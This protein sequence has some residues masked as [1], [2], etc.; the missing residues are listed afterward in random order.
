MKKI[1][2]LIIGCVFA[3]IAEGAF[4]LVENGESGAVICVPAKPS[5]FEE[6]T[7]RELQNY[8]K[9]ISGAELEIVKN[10][11]LPE[12]PAII[13]G[14]HPANREL[15]AALDKAATQ[16]DRFAIE[17]KGSYLHIAAPHSSGISYGGWEFLQQLGVEWLMP[18]KMGT[19]IPTQKTIKL[20]DFRQIH[21]PRCEFRS[22]TNYIDAGLEWRLEQQGAELYVR[23]M[24][25]GFNAAHMYAWRMRLNSTTQDRRDAYAILGAGH[26]YAAY[27]PIE[28]YR[29]DHPE[30]YGLRDGKRQQPG[31]AWQI[32]F[33]NQEAA[34]EFAKNALQ[35]V[36]ATLGSGVPQERIMLCV[37]PNDHEV[38]CLCDKCNAMKDPDGYSSN[39]LN[40]ANMVAAHIH[41]KYP[42]VKITYYVYHTYGRVPTKVKPAP[43]VY[44]FITAWTAFNSLAVNNAKPLMNPG[45]NRIFADVFKWFVENSAGVYVYPYYG[46]YEIFSCWPMQTQMNYDF[47][48][49][50]KCPKFLGM[51][52][53][54][55]LHW[56]TQPL[57]LY[58]FPKLL[59]NPDADQAALIQNFCRKAY[60]AAADE[61]RQLFA[62]QQAQMDRLDYICGN[63]IEVRE[64]LTPQVI[65][66]CDKLTKRIQAKMPRMDEPTRWRTQILLDGWKYSK[67]YAEAIN[68]LMYGTS[69]DLQPKIKANFEA[70]TDFV[71][72]EHGRYVFVAGTIEYNLR[73]YRSMVEVNLHDLPA[74]KSEWGG[75]I[76]YGSALKF[77]A[78]MRNINYGLWGMH[79]PGKSEGSFDWTLKTRAGKIKAL[80]IDLSL[81]DGSLKVY[82]GNDLIAE[83]GGPVVIPAKYLNKPEITIRV[84]GRNDKDNEVIW[85]AGARVN[86]EVE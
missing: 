60:G 76:Y 84:T 65:G 24:E 39:V 43:G 36:E 33:N 77:Y 4:T 64:L 57:N 13:V 34:A 29:K 69:P 37:S 32:C 49:M 16:Y 35:E 27:L 70:I 66:E 31:E 47:K 1:L 61:A 59:W 86:A 85:I 44:A 71:K 73:S 83:K 23:E 25:N 51:N 82:V 45:G 26:S 38:F 7:A 14:N 56:G 58:L 19:Y 41:A 5:P 10:D 8:L 17:C 55:H 53:E 63:G 22:S 11:A 2:L 48:A 30:W 62:V 18:G 9:A 72:S 52:S 20:N 28:R 21:E 80:T 3:V 50:A 81:I 42:A 79:L 15:L 75:A 12:T 67:L 46:H 40:F 68:S 74:G 6:F 78:K 54:S